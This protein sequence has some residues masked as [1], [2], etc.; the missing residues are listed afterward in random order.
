MPWFKAQITVAVEAEDEDDAR[1]TLEKWLDR[2]DDISKP[3]GP[4]SWE[5]D[6]DEEEEEEDEV[7]DL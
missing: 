4:G 3:V 1:Y 2:S 7:D 6:L 5:I